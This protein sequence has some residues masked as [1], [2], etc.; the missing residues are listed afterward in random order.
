[1]IN[2]GKMQEGLS[3]VIAMKVYYQ[4]SESCKAFGKQEMVSSQVT[5]ENEKKYSIRWASVN[6][7]RHFL[8]AI[9]STE[10]KPDS[11]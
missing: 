9:S 4:Q 11:R 3:T 2:K 6:Q 10:T 8:G 5:T 7:T 1:M